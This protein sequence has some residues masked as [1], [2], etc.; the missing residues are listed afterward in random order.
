MEQ[1]DK[2]CN[3]RPPLQTWAVIGFAVFFI[4]GYLCSLPCLC[5]E[6]AVIGFYT[7]IL[8]LIVVLRLLYGV[9]NRNMKVSDYVLWVGAFTVFFIFTLLI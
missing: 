2:N 8:Y 3:K 4:L 7:S 6:G 5:R 9:L 1:F